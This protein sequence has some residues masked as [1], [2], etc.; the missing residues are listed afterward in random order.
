MSDRHYLLKVMG[1]SAAPRIVTMVLTMVSFP[2]MVRALGPSNF[3]VIVFIGAITAVMESFVDF[4]VS[5]A[6]GK[7]IAAA[8]ETGTVPLATVVQRWARLQA[9]VALIG[10]LPLVGF[11]YLAASANSRIEFGVTVLVLLVLAAWITICLNFV[12]A[13]LTSLLAFR[14]LAILDSFESVVR[15]ASWLCVAYRVPSTLG[16]ATANVL[17]ALSA[18]GVGA[19][20]LWRSVRRGHATSLATGEGKE[21]SHATLSL[22]HM[23]HESGTFLWLRFAT[24]IFLSVPLL[25]FGRLFGSEVVGV[26]GAFAKI[27]D[28]AS[29][30]FSVIGNALAV[31]AVGVAARGASAAKSLWDV[32]ARIIAVAVLAAT[33]VYLCANVFMHLLTPGIQGAA[34]IMRV[35]SIT[36]VTTAISAVVTP[37]SDYVG[38]L[39]LRNILLTGFAVVQALAIW[40]GAKAFGEF[41]ALGAY[42]IVLSLMNCGYVVI[43]LAAFFPSAR[44]EF[45]SEVSYF[46]KTTFAALVLTLSLRHLFGLSRVSS[47]HTF[48]GVIIDVAV[49][50]VIVLASIALHG[51]A[52][53]FFITKTFFDFQ[54]GHG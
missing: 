42:V 6:A 51:P 47:S 33:T 46:L 7:A 45:R 49:F 39:R 40:T 31:R 24:R 16:L 3:G 37:M 29:F 50:W 28:L 44:Y 27:I 23:L 2:L 18:S 21:S 26:V 34:A 25:M 22:R 9:T 11:T 8:R 48:L 19:V 14:S 54:P 53:R 35:L 36:V 15:S 38:A 1:L 43:A 13:S 30:P 20:L 41:G 10:L 5:S 52:K 12:R 32:V 17:T 4:G